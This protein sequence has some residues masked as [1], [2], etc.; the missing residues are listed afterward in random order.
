[1]A[2]APFNASR[3]SPLSRQGG[4]RACRYWLPLRHERQ[5]VAGAPPPPRAVD[6]ARSDRTVTASPPVALFF[7]ISPPDCCLAP[8]R[9]GSLTAPPVQLR[10]RALTSLLPV[11]RAEHGD[12]AGE[13]VA[14]RENVHDLHEAAARGLMDT[15]G[16]WST[17]AQTS[18][19]RTKVHPLPAHQHTHTLKPP[20][21]PPREAVAATLMCPRLF[22]LRLRGCFRA[23][24][25]QRVSLP[26]VVLL[27][28]ELSLF[29]PDGDT[30]LHV[31]ASHNMPEV[32]ALLLLL[33]RCRRGALPQ[34]PELSAPPPP[35]RRC[36]RG[37]CASTCWTTVRTRTP[38]TTRRASRTP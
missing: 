30:A 22:P 8:P 37:R 15:T 2:A 13:P 36:V 18:P 14:P 38:P 29:G 24:P 12:R 4:G 6:P 35:A 26:A 16:C 23:G 32:R 33:L 1:M 17:T 27:L 19:P 20:P 21:P 3:C 28:P 31:A 11:N 9:P 25:A 5:V 7:R 10:A 34:C